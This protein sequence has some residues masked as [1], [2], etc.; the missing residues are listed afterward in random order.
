MLS[1]FQSLV[2]HNKLHNHE[3]KE[4]IYLSEELIKTTLPDKIKD[5]DKIA[6]NE[7]NSNLPPFPAPIVK[8]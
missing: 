5:K 6:S 2:S 7:K 8:R 1:R 3:A 4:S